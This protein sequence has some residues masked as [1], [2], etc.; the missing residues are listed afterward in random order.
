M[1]SVEFEE[2]AELVEKHYPPPIGHSIYNSSGISVERYSLEDRAVSGL[3][4]E[5]SA[6]Q[7]LSKRSANGESIARIDRILGQL[8]VASR[9]HRRLLE[10]RIADEEGPLRG[11]TLI[12]NSHEDCGTN[13]VNIR[14]KARK[15]P[16]RHTVEVGQYPGSS[17]SQVERRYGRYARQDDEGYFEHCATTSISRTDNLDDATL[18]LE[19]SPHLAKRLPSHQEMRYKIIS[20]LTKNDVV[21]GPRKK[22]LNFPP[23]TSRIAVDA[24]SIKLRRVSL[25]QSSTLTHE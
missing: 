1:A 4:R 11:A 10:Q 7:K 18:L 21:T 2:Y 20:Q 25:G 16:E 19:S 15:R 6:R 9:N 13:F 5:G 24:S 23:Q 8:H 3:D 17:V 12:T 22:L 14:R